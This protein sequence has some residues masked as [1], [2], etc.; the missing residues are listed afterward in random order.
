MPVYSYKAF[1]TDGKQISGVKD[2]DNVRALRANLKRDGIYLTSAHEAHLRAAEIGEKAPSVIA[3]WKLRRET[4]RRH[5]AILTRQL[6]V[7]LKAGVPLS[8]ALAALVDQADSP[9]LKRIL[10]DVKTQV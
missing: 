6:G 7:L 3:M 1:A 2:A 10:A 9:G 8:E 5:V 4:D